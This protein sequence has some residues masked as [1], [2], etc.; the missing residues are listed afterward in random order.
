MTNISPLAGATSVPVSFT[1]PADLSVLAASGGGAVMPG[2]VQWTIPSLP[3]GSSATFTVDVVLG[4]DAPD[5]KPLTTVAAA[6]GALNTATIHVMVPKPEVGCIAVHKQL[7]AYDGSPINWDNSALLGTRPVFSFMLDGG[8]KTV[9]SD[10]DGNAVFAAVPVGSHSIGEVSLSGWNLQSVSPA[11]GAVTVTTGSCATMLFTNARSTPPPALTVS[12]TVSQPTVAPGGTLTY[13]VT[14]TNSS[15]VTAWNVLVAHALPAWGSVTPLTPGAVQTGSVNQWTL[16]YLPSLQSVSF[17]VQLDV[18]AGTAPGTAI[19]S[20]ATAQGPLVPVVTN[21]ITSTVTAPAAPVTGCLDIT[22]QI[23]PAPGIPALPAGTPLPSFTL[24]VTRVSPSPDGS[25][26][27]LLS[28]GAGAAGVAGLQPG[29][30]TVAESPLSGWQQV[31]PPLQTVTVAAG[32]P[33]ASV[34]FQ[35]QPVVGSP[36]Y[37][38]SL[39]D[40]QATADPGQILTY[41][42]TASNISPVPSPGPVTVSVRLPPELTFLSTPGGAAAGTYDSATDTVSWIVPSLVIGAPASFSLQAQVG[43]AL[44]D[45]VQIVATALMSDGGPSTTDLTVVERPVTA[46]TGCIRIVAK[47]YDPWGLPLPVSALPQFT[48]LLDGNGDTT[49]R[50]NEFGIAVEPNIPVGLHSLTAITPPDA[51]EL[52]WRLAFLSPGALTLVTKTACAPVTA[53]FVQTLPDAD[54]SSS[55]SAPPGCGDGVCAVWSIINRENCL[56]CEADCGPCSSASSTPATSSSDSSGATSSS[57]SSYRPAAC[58]CDIPLCPFDESFCSGECGTGECASA[59]ASDFW[60]LCTD[61]SSSSSLSASTTTTSSSSSTSSSSTSAS[62]PSTSAS[63]ATSS[64]SSA[65]SSSAASDLWCDHRMIFPP[66]CPAYDENTHVLQEGTVMFSY[67]YTP[68]SCSGVCD[69]AKSVGMCCVPTEGCIEM[70]DTDC[71]NFGAQFFRYGDSAR[72]QPAFDQGLC[73]GPP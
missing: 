47:T 3:A 42:V 67:A 33:C 61:S 58:S 54:P 2:Q 41:V 68:L 72:C 26:A 44:P 62:A 21:T 51:G 31:G 38:I 10:A 6:P 70:R 55:S 14:V 63:S 73:G 37:L 18:P 48:F 46:E 11:G 39:T 1:V 4:T 35:Q 7:L 22:H 34:L 60:W 57:V 45:G 13:V 5:G 64:V 25:P 52:R 49:I 28:D 23:L 53:V 16:P 65:S 27:T 17:Q 69:N 50:T 12:Q 59:C 20:V 30:Y 71:G 43:A 8:I 56:L 36:V 32:T 40:L 15:P 29:T 19:P 9:A 66:V 24:T